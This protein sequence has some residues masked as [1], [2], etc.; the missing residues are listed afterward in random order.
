L[1]QLTQDEVVCLENYA[2]KHTLKSQSFN[3]FKV[4]AESTVH[5]P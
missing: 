2:V 3:L 1:K 5:E 4:Q